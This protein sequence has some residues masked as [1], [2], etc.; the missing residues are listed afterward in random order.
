MKTSNCRKEFAIW[1][2]AFKAVTQLSPFSQVSFQT[3]KAFS[4]SSS[5]SNMDLKGALPVF[6]SYN[7]VFDFKTNF[8]NRS[9]RATESHG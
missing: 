3:L 6:V 2:H 7:N 8:Y 5:T 1:C 4:I 9:C